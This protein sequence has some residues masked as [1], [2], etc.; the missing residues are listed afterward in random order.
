MKYLLINSIKWWRRRE[1]NPRSTAT[2]TGLRGG[3]RH[4]ADVGRHQNLPGP[5]SKPVLAH[6][7]P[8]AFIIPVIHHFQ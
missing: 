1:S 6:Y 4:V 8:D 2:G 3:G 5:A 7:L